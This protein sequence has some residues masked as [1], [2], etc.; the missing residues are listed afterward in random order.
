MDLCSIINGRNG[1]CP[2]DCKYCAQSAHHQTNCEV[3][4]FLPV[5]TILQKCRMI[6]AYEI[7]REN[8]RIDLCTSMGFIS[9]EQLHRLK[10]VGVT[11]YHHNIETS[12]RFFPSTTHTYEMKTLKMVKEEGLN[13]IVHIWTILQNCPLYAPVII[14]IVSSLCCI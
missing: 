1:K 11:S 8:T 10:K 14:E 12:K 4:D 9:R 2:E 5:N 3:Y 13:F 6:E 7:L